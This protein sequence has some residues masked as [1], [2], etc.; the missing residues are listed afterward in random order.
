LPRK[1][2]EGAQIRRLEIRLAHN[3]PVRFIHFGTSG[4][5]VAKSVPTAAT[6]PAQSTDQSAPLLFKIGDATITPVGFVDLTNT[7]STANVGTGLQ[8]NFTAIPY[9]NTPQ[10]RVIEDNF[11]AANSRVGLR[12]DTKVKDLTLL[13]TGRVIL[14]V[15]SV[16]PPSTRR[17][18]VI[19]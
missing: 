8:T 13:A 3:N 6:T 11:T 10:G 9:G 1:G 15:V 7:R 19:A 4:G 17:S 12:V 2:N 14:L 5:S 16:T 18:R